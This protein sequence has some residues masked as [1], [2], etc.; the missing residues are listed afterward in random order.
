M[1]PTL[2]AGLVVRLIALANAR[3]KGPRL[4]TLGG[5]V[6]Y[7]RPWF[8]ADTHCAMC[9]ID[10]KVGFVASLGSVL[11]GFRETAELAIA[12][13]IEAIEGGKLPE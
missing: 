9:I 6:R 1:E 7:E 10:G 8:A 11:G 5:E 4:M 12:S 13:L 2:I 3:T